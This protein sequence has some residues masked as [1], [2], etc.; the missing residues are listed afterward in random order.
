MVF[1]ALVVVSLVVV[2]YLVYS[3]LNNPETNTKYVDVVGVT[4]INLTSPPKTLDQVSITDTTTIL[5]TAQNNAEQNG[6]Y[7]GKNWNLTFKPSTYTTFIVTQG[8][9]YTGVSYVYTPLSKTYTQLAGSGNTE[10]GNVS[11]D[12]ITCNTITGS[13][14]QSLQPDIT[15]V[16][17]QSQALNMGNQKIVGAAPPTNENDV[18][19][20]SYMDNFAQGVVWRASVQAAT[21][22]VLPGTVT[23][24]NGT[25]G[26]GAT[27]T[28]DTALGTVNTFSTWEDGTTRL[29][30]KDEINQAHC[31]VYI[32]TTNANPF[33]LTR[34]TDFDG[35]PLNETK[36]GTGVY[37]EGSAYSG[38]RYVIGTLQSGLTTPPNV[39]VGT[40]DMAFVLF[41]KSTVSPRQCIVE[42]VLGANV[43][44]GTFTAGS[45]LT[46]PLNT[47]NDIG[48]LG[49]TLNANVISVPAGTYS[50]SAN[51]KAW[52]VI[53]HS[54]RIQNTTDATTLGV[55]A[56]YANNTYPLVTVYVPKI[57]FNTDVTVELQHRCEVTKTGDGWGIAMTY[58]TQVNA[59][60]IW[61]RLS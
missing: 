21:N 52:G 61:T 42:N 35:D 36:V 26:V 7:L 24:N 17:T 20:K 58:S 37:V 29:L 31:G 13:Q 60:T 16:G 14:K 15:G 3:Q 18:V 11:F 38:N 8:V 53:D 30:V 10:G 25:D 46:R 54:L 28:G 5:L 50:V 49:I 2:F 22:T 56:T 41:S 1:Y 48:S 59:Q 44:G 6:V 23:Y 12:N 19:N 55:N 45:W 32:V 34:A 39:K 27:L 47:V 57:T 40:D 43:T 4:N 51:A 33:V 9:E